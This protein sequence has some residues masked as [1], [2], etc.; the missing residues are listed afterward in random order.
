MDS[1]TLCFSCRLGEG[2]GPKEP[3]LNVLCHRLSSTGPK[4]HAGLH[5][6]NI[7]QRRPAQSMTIMC[8][9]GIPV[10]LHM[11]VHSE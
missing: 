6:T 3:F 8:S 11:Q 5:Q 2:K 7:L 4:F 9:V 10:E 1:C